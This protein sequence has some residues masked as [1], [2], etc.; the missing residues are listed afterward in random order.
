M[1][2]NMMN[3]SESQQPLS[4]A[5]PRDTG[6]V[7]ALTTSAG[8]ASAPVVSFPSSPSVST[9]QVPPSPR[10]PQTR[11][12]FEYQYPLRRRALTS[13]TGLS[14]V[15]ASP[16]SIPNPDPV[17]ASASASTTPT[18]QRTLLYD[19]SRRSVPGFT[20]SQPHRRTPAASASQPPS[21]RLA[22]EEDSVDAT[23]STVRVLSPNAT[24]RRK[25]SFN[26]HQTS[27]NV[28]RRMP[29]STVSYLQSRAP[30]DER[31]HRAGNGIENGNGNGFDNY[32]SEDGARTPVA[33][34]SRL[35]NEDIFLNI[36]RSDSTRRESFGRSDLR[37]VSEL[38]FLCFPSVRE[39]TAAVGLQPTDGELSL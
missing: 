37:R 8:D 28:K 19:R 9:S 31:A 36:A 13:Q 7:G 12:N 38:I 20:F 21:P 14:S 27:P 35:K 24:K 23:G 32:G 3:S 30:T 33:D 39:E 11:F 6:R 18:P 25:Q 22:L 29:S 17:S 5:D 10:V 16:T 26:A 34:D 4:P 2:G 15:D 1:N